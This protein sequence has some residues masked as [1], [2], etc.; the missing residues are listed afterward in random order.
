MT[1]GSSP[2]AACTTGRGSTG[3]EGAILAPFDG[4]HGWFWRNRDSQPVTVTVQLR[5]EYAELKQMD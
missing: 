5:G 4:E 3:S 2:V 1:G